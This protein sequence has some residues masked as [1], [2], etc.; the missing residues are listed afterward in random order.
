VTFNQGNAQ[1]GLKK[2]PGSKIENEVL[3]DLS[4]KTHRF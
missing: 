1:L 2:V 3:P 4:T